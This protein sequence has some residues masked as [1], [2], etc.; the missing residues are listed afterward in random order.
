M[1]VEYSKKATLYMALGIVAMF[2]IVGLTSAIT[3]ATT[4]K[5]KGASTGAVFVA[6]V[7]LIAS[8]LGLILGGVVATRLWGNMAGLGVGVY[9]RSYSA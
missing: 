7:N 6:W 2:V 3:V 9:G 4:K 5:S 1:D 8:L